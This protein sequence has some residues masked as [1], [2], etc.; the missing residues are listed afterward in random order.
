MSKHCLQASEV[1]NSRMFANKP[2]YVSWY[3]GFIWSKEQQIADSH[4]F[5]S[6]FYTEVTPYILMSMCAQTHAFTYREKYNFKN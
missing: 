1:D 6:D 3:P 2:D 5:F 4:T